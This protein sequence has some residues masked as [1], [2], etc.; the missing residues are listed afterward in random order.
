MPCTRKNLLQRRQKDWA[1]RL[2]LGD[3]NRNGAV[4]DLAQTVQFIPAFLKY[5]SVGDDV[6]EHPKRRRNGVG[7]DGYRTSQLKSR[8]IFQGDIVIN[9][10]L[11]SCLK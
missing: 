10:V 5:C 6:P 3:V 4:V 8:N 1:R 2:D 9:T 11:V 7:Q